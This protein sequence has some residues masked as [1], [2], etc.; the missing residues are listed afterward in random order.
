LSAVS[1]VCQLIHESTFNDAVSQKFGWL[2]SRMVSMLHSGAEGSGFKSQVAVLS[3]NR[4][5]Q[6]VHTHRASVHQA[7]KLVAAV[8]RVARITAGLAESSDSRVY[9]S[10]YLQADCQEP[11]SALEPCTW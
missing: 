6:T 8:L 4:L 2:G 5:R 3:G 11:E 10:C 1:S 9:D 7:A